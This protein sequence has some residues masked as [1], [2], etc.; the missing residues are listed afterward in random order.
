MG[1][2]HRLQIDSF[3]GTMRQRVIVRCKHWLS[4][5]VSIAKVATP[6]EQMKTW[7]PPRVDIHVIATSGRVTSDA[8][9]AAE[10]HKHSD[11]RVAN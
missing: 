7:K 3:G 8:I 10:K 5:S 11:Q 6:R 2:V 4:K 1:S 9:L